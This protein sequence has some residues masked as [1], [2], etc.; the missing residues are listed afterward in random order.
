MGDSDRQ[1]IEK[2]KVCYFRVKI[3][4]VQLLCNRLSCNFLSPELFDGMPQSSGQGFTACIRGLEFKSWPGGDRLLVCFF[5]GRVSEIRQ[6]LLA[7]V[8]LP[9]CCPL[10]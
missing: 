6:L 4:R 5:Y 1:V 3:C 2:A 10:T 7:F 9:V 8:S